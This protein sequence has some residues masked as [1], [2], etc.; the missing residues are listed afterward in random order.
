MYGFFLLKS[1][2]KLQIVRS[3][4]LHPVPLVISRPAER[5]YPSRRI[6]GVITAQY[7]DDPDNKFVLSLTL[8]C[9]LFIL[10][11]NNGLFYLAKYGSCLADRNG[12]N[13]VSVK[14]SNQKMDTTFFP[15]SSCLVD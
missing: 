7:L 8:V 11:R 13:D 5:L 15:D 9:N 10:M 14:K 4:N 1:C 6:L 2:V 3:V 12:V